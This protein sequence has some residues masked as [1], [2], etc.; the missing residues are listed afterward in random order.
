MVEPPEPTRRS[1]PLWL[2][3]YPDVLLE[4]LG[5]ISLG[6]E[7]RYE[8]AESVAL[9][10][11]AA[12]QH[13]PPRQRCVL[14]LRDVLGFP[15][16]EVAGILDTTEASVK[17]AL[18]RARSTLRE[19]LPAER[20][21]RATLPSPKRER[22]VVGR[23]RREL[24]ARAH[25]GQRS[26]RV[27]LLSARR[28]RGHRPRLWPD[29]S[30]LA[31]RPDLGHHLVCRPCSD[32]PVRPAPHAPHLGATAGMSPRIEAAHSAASTSAAARS[33][34]RMAPS[35]VPCE[36]VAVSVPAQWMRPTGA[37]SARPNRVSTPGGM[38]A[39]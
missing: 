26:A 29:G 32:G 28:P 16:G 22:E 2:E 24:H 14:V 25:R 17:G 12:L 1:E 13:L 36:T 6:P 3:P 33:P 8:A 9:A 21:D 35:I 11:V 5:D 39:M 31:R 27:R 34:D 23:A 20:P 10:F 7:A 19:R 18:Q 37:R 4:G 15:A 38:C 30:H